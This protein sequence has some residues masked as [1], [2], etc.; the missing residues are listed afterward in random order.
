MFKLFKKDETQEV[1]ITISSRTVFKVLLGTIVAVLFLGALRQAQH[2]LIL[3]FTAFFLSLALNA[4]VQWIARHLP[5]KLRGKRSA[6]TAMSF[7][8]VIVLIGLF[9]AS[10]VPPLVHQTQTFIDATPSLIEDARHG[11]GAIGHVIRQYHLESQVDN[12]SSQLGDRLKGIGGAAITSVGKIGSSVFAVLTI[13]VLTFMM[14]IE[15]PRALDFFRELIPA[16]KRKNADRLGLEMY[17]VIKG[18]INGQVTLAALAALLISPVLFLFH[19]PY[20]L[21]LVVVVF[22]CGLIPMV[23][24]TIGAVIVTLV[25]LSKSPGVALIVLGYYILYQQMENYLI[26]PRIQANSTNMSPLLV[27]MSVVIG[28]SFGGLFGGLFA[29]PI[30]GCIRIV[31]LDYLKNHEYIANKPVVE[32]EIEKAVK[33]DTK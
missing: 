10:I 21:A 1:E 6:A 29:I 28:V 20:A 32:D 9:I 17:G 4:P 30:A 13:L 25:A 23:G 18:Y 16:R 31:I 14:I 27:F 7:L 8:L 2:A 24:H 3:I 22:I 33:N 15:G 19:I 12:F 5:G 11:N 26:Q